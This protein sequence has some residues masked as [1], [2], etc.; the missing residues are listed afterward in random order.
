MKKIITYL[1]LLTSFVASAQNYTNYN[2]TL[3]STVEFPGQ[4][5]AN[6]C[7]YAVNG[8][9]YAL[10][11]GSLGLIIVDVT[12][13]YAPG[14]PYQIVDGISSLWREIKV[15]RNFAYMNSEGG[16]GI[17]IYDLTPL[18]APPAPPAIPTI[19]YTSYTGNGAIAGLLGKSH[20][21]HIDTLKGFAY[22]FGA[23]TNGNAS[24]TSGALVLNLQPNPFSP[25]YAGQYNAN[26][27]HDGFV[28]NDTLYS[29]DIYQGR[30]SIINFVNKSAPV[31]LATQTTPNAFTHNTWRTLNRK[32]LLTTDERT[33]SF[34]AA[35]DVSDPSNIRFLDKLQLTPGSGSI[36]H[37]THVRDCWAISSWYRDGINIVDITRPF[38]LVQVGAFDTYPLAT[39]NGFDGAWGVYPYLPSGVQIVSNITKSG[40]SNGEMYVLIPTF[41]KACF[42]EGIVTD[43]ITGV[44]LGNVTVTIV[45]GDM[46]SATTT[47]NLSAGTDTLGVYHTGQPTAGVFQVC[48]AAV[49]YITKCVS[50]TLVNGQVT[51]Q[52]IQLATNVPL[53]LELLSFSGKAN[54]RIN[55]LE[56]QTRDEENVKEFVVLRSSNGVSDWS[57][58]G[59]LAAD[60][61]ITSAR[62]YMFGDIKPPTKSYYRLKIN[63]NDGRYI[64][65]K[66]I[67]VE[68][69]DEKVGILDIYPVPAN[70]DLN[71]EFNSESTQS[72]TL[73]LQD[74]LGRVLK[75]IE[76]TTQIGKNY[77][78]IDV[79]DLAQGTYFV[80][81]QDG[82]KEIT[83]KFVKK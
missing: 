4:T 41:K 9:E 62:Q 5:A 29:G 35:Y 50:A 70:A 15:Y 18:A 10:V 30:F 22:I 45:G 75:N 57:E 58:I 79:S 17:K 67:A 51:F 46:N 54:G 83:N 60:G 42:L 65:S 13:P 63:D 56:W 16:G 38:N 59:K 64:F 43:S 11:G 23:T 39:G 81:L 55:E 76:T 40:T 34:L 25:N 72:V 28:E 68:R 52:N 1:L 21:L 36:V 78:K 77:W 24:M 47:P 32:T 31:L 14:P 37:N 26:Y 44:K 82:N 53:P 12:N 73:E 7:G 33:N 3:A 8:R 48:Y 69:K 27:I 80:K 74:V 66:V 19:S 2:L 61:K 49:G 6:I 20:A 71:V